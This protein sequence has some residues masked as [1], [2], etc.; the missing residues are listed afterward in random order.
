[1]LRKERTSTAI[2]VSLFVSVVMTMRSV[3][4]H[5]LSVLSV[6]PV[7]CFFDGY[8]YAARNRDNRGCTHAAA[9]TN[10]TTE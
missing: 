3:Q 6:L 10:T 7:V 1:M 4:I 9:A 5:P 8:A 2:F